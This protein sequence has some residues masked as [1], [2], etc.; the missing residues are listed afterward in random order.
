MEQAVH[1]IEA[2]PQAV[3]R[4]LDTSNRA[5]RSAA[6]DNLSAASGWQAD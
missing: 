5:K 6:S 4:P 1:F 2:K 3:G